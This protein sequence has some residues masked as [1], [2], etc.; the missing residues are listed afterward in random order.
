MTKNLPKETKLGTHDIF[1]GG[2]VSYKFKTTTFKK[3][4]FAHQ[5]SSTGGVA[6]EE[7][8]DIIT[9]PIAT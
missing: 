9:S 6:E 7:E 2:L 1:V 3:L 8:I 4:R 5:S